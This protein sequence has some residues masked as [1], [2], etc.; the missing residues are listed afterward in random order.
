LETAIHWAE[1]RK[2]FLMFSKLLLGGVGLFVLTVAGFTFSLNQPPAI[3]VE[4]VVMVVADTEPVG[5][6]DSEVEAADPG[7][8][9]TQQTLADATQRM[10]E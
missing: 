8:S 5:D 4:D 3:A 2:E 6:S 9:D 7:S 1:W 10:S